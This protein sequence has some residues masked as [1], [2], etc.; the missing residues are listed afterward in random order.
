MNVTY[1]NFP[2]DNRVLQG[3]NGQVQPFNQM[4]HQQK[5][6]FMPTGNMVNIYNALIHGIWGSNVSAVNATSFKNVNVGD[7]IFLYC[8]L[9]GGED[10]EKQGFHAVGIIVGKKDP[11]YEDD[12]TFG[13]GTYGNI[14]EV[15]WLNQPRKDRVFHLIEAQELVPFSKWR[16]TLQNGQYVNV[17]NSGW[18]LGSEP[19]NKLINRLIV[20]KSSN[21][22]LKDKMERLNNLYNDTVKNKKEVI[23]KYPKV[24]RKIITEYPERPIVEQKVET[25]KVE[26]V[27]EL[28]EEEK[29]KEYYNKKW[30]FYNPKNWE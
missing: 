29:R 20:G 4:N 26:E 24:E 2:T 14:V 6:Y 12:L 7:M 30:T 28:T 8:S 22:M 5:I 9:T 27:K 10:K 3:E 19:L 11:N 17:T 13:D 25:P 1:H 16:W 18:G 21:E 15:K 23:V